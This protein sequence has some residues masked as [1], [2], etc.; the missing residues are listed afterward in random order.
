MMGLVDFKGNE[1]IYRSD[2][3]RNKHVSFMC[4]DRLILLIKPI[5]LRS[6]GSFLAQLLCSARGSETSFHGKT[7]SSPSLSC[8]Y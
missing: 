2:C 5:S 4:R 3:Q 7:Q 6:M 8:P 1:G